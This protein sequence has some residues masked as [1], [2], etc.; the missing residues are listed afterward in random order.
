MSL[1]D[2]LPAQGSPAPTQAPPP[3]PMRP[4]FPFP[5]PTEPRPLTAGERA[6]AGVD[7]ESCG[8]TAPCGTGG[9]WTC[10]W[11]APASYWNGGR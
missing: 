2:G 5:R 4:A 11:H 7:G 9:V 8:L 3:P 10:A 6:C 1:F